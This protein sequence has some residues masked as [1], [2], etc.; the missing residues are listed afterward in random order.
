M[1]WRRTI[2]AGDLWEGALADVDVRGR[3]VM[4]V[5]L[6]GGELRAYEGHCPHQGVALAQGE[7]DGRFLVCSAHAW[8]FDLATG[9]GVNP[10]G[11]TLRRYP[12]SER[13]ARIFVGLE[14]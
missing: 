8:R 10:A 12:V 3:Q 5:R 13:G 7:F 11:C 2:P 6:P 9:L 4:L 1:S 14:A